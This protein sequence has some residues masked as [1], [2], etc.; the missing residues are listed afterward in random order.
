MFER[1]ND[2]GFRYDPRPY[3]TSKYRVRKK[4]ITGFLLSAFRVSPAQ[5]FA[6]RGKV[7]SYLCVFPAFVA[8]K[9]KI[10]PR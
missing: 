9:L 7:N 5:R 3:A 2:T 6:E 1:R 10:L 4:F 8:A